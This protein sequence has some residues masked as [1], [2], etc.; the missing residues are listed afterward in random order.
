MSDTDIKSLMYGF[1]P[2]RDLT[3]HEV[4]DSDDTAIVRANTSKHTIDIC[5]FVNDISK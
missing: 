1:A 5:S 3:F 4:I 2:L